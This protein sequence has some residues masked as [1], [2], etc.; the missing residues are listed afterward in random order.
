MPIAEEKCPHSLSFLLPCVCRG[1]PEP[2]FCWTKRDLVVSASIAPLERGHREGRYPD[3]NHRG[4]VT[5]YFS[6]IRPD[7]APASRRKVGK[8]SA[9]SPAA[10]WS[11]LQ[12][13]L[14]LKHPWLPV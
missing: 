11:P 4:G 3:K 2:C 14:E 1:H 6:I 5:Y 8:L 7:K 12:R 10:H 13:R 9:A